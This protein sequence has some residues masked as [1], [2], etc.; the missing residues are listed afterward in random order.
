[1]LDEGTNNRIQNGDLGD[2]QYASPLKI[3]PGQGSTD[4]FRPSDRFG[5][6]KLDHP[7]TVLAVPWS[8]SDFDPILNQLAAE[9]NLD[10]N[11]DGLIAPS[12]GAGA[13][14]E[15]MGVKEGQTSSL[16]F[17]N[18]LLAEKTERPPAPIPKTKLTAKNRSEFA[19]LIS[20]Y[21]DYTNMVSLSA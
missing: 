14:N 9:A 6:Q 1:M 21:A 17:D 10:S 3:T 7:R 19:D 4:P 20:Q 13:G 16:N 18:G 12:G 8:L 2:Y 11:S 15:I 5:T